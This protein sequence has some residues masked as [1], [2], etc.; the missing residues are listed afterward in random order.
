MHPYKLILLTLFLSFAFLATSKASAN[1]EQSC[2]L[3]SVTEQVREHALLNQFKQTKRIAI[4]SKPLVSTGYLLVSDELGVVWQTSQPLKGT[5]VIEN[6]SLKQFNKH[7]QAVS[8]PANSNQQA[9]QLITSTFLA[10]LAGDFEQ[11]ERNFSA[12]L[13]C[14]E[15]QWQIQLQAKH[16]DMRRL[17]TDITI[18]GNSNIQQLIFSEANGDT[19]EL[20][21]TPFEDP[22]TE[23]ALGLYFVR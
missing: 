22:A 15:T 8:A 17:L 4:L 13:I 1:C 7:D 5:I 14:D 9:S 21:F 3:K 23:E 19:T 16:D 6:D 20:V 2:S 10:I 12:E 18:I 11:L